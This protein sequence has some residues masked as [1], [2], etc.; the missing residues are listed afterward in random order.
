MVCDNRW[1]I[2]G[3]DH[4]QIAAPPGCEAQA[5]WFFGSVLGITELEKPA[6]LAKRGGCWFQC[7]DQQLHIGVEQ[8]FQPARKAHPAF[9]VRY[10]ISLKTRLN[11]YAIA[12]REDNA[13]PE[14]KRIFVDDPWGNRLE[15]ME[16]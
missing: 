1:V 13:N 10:L 4:V 5:R 16:G 6:E 3:I 12:F 9:R 7:G 15:F 11:V 2:L 14:A 8:D